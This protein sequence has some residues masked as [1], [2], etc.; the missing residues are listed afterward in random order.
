M[1][2][3]S[4]IESLLS[5]AG[6]NINGHRPYDVQIN[7]ERAYKRWVSEVELGL[8]ESYLDKWWTCN[9]L[10]EFFNK[11][12]SAHVEQKVS[13]GFKMALYILF[14]KLIN[15]QTKTKA[16]RVGREHYD[17]GNE[18]FR[19]ML[20]ERMCYSSA[21]WK[22]AKTLDEAQEAKLDLICKK[23]YLKQGMKVLD[24]GCGWGSFAKFAAEKYGVE[25]LG[26]SISKNQI[27]LGRELCKG[28][29]I[30]LRFQDY[31]NVTG[32]YDA[33]LSI[34]FFEH[35]GYKN[36][37]KYIKLVDHC[38][39]EEGISL[40]H[41]IGNNFSVTY[42]NKWTNKYIF[43]NGMIPSLTQIAEAAEGLFVIEDL[44]N[45]GLDYDKTLMAWYANFEQAWPTLKEYYGE[46]FY[47]IWRYFL[48]SSAG[49]FRSRTNQLWQI[50]LTKQGRKK[51]YYRIR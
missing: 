7:N 16:K 19:S 45:F 1:D 10:D 21:Y 13:R 24:I 3:K 12:L 25:V 26:I 49:G 28:L 38:L 11:L 37:R 41:T 23:L 33:I 35:V 51:P 2:A 8:G 31:R 32:T 5:E 39:T 6:I 40:I 47:R 15:R 42:A 44:H 50:V 20:D 34:G 18:L 36:Y 14:S 48:L 17:L 43:P 30:E 29:P 46:R 27:E 9:A 4:L 22:S